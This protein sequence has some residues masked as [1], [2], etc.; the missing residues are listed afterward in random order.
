MAIC[1][2]YRQWQARSDESAGAARL[3]YEI[4][5]NPA[6]GNRRKVCAFLLTRELDLRES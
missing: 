5:F 2:A 3:D 6:L 4:L 1:I